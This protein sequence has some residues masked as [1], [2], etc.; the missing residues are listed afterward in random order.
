MRRSKRHLSARLR[1]CVKALKELG[2][3]KIPE[4]ARERTWER[5]RAEL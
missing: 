4:G 5:V 3:V 1:A 2:A